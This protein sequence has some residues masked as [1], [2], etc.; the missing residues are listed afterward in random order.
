MVQIKMTQAEWEAKVRKIVNT[1]LETAARQG[2]AE[3]VP[4]NPFSPET[5]SFP[6]IKKD[7][8]MQLEN[9]IVNSFI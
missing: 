1:T 3:L 4:A 5:S 7:S 2:E 9:Q 6:S 8:L